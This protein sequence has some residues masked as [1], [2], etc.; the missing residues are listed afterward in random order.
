MARHVALVGERR[1]AG[2]LPPREAQPI[3]VD[4]PAARLPAGGLPPA[5]GT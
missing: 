1:L 3:Y 4:P 2:E 5:P